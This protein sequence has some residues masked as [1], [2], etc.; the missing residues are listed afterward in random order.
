MARS[1][2]SLQF[3]LLIVC[4]WNFRVLTYDFDSFDFDMIM[5]VATYPSIEGRGEIKR[6]VFQKGEHAG[7]DTNV[8]SRKVLEKT[9][10]KG[11]GNFKEK[12]SGV[13]YVRRRY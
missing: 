8:Y 3:C 7:V 6:C 11:S 2:G 4:S 13:I 10:K 5:C 1:P 9:K 12:G